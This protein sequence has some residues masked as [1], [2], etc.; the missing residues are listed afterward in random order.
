MTTLQSSGGPVSDFEV[1]MVDV[2]PPEQT[3]LGWLG[4]ARLG[5]AQTALGSIVVLTTSTI[6]RVM[7][8]ELS[9]PAMIPGALV[10]LHYAVQ[11]LRPRWG[12]GAD[13]GGRL[14]PWIIGGMAML[15]LGGIGAAVATVLMATSFWL[16]FLLSIVAFI[17]VGVGVGASGTSLLVLL[18][19]RVADARRPA[20]ATIVWIMMIVGF[21]ITAATAGHFL[22]PFS[23][24]RL[25]VV[26]TVVSCVAMVM[27]LLAV[28]GVEGK[29]VKGKSLSHQAPDQSF[30]AAMIEVWSEPQS[31]LF[32]IFIFISMVA[33]SAQD[34]ILEPFAGVVFAYTP[35]QSTKL[36]SVQH[37]GVLVGMILVAIGTSLKGGQLAGSSR[38]WTVGGCVASAVMLLLLASSAFIGPS[39][40]FRETVFMLG[41]ANGAFAISAIGAMMRLVS[42]G[43]KS[44]EGVRMGLWGAAQ[45]VAFGIGGFLGTAAVDFARVLTPS[46]VLAY[47]SVFAA[48]AVLFVVAAVL[49]ERVASQAHGALITT[50]SQSTRL[51]DNSFVL[52][53]KT[54]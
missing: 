9:L 30:R 36:A 10:A 32:A 43:H 6:N 37:G 34:L 47:A 46:P 40:P 52:G 49:A 50:V 39:F 22:D 23:M 45:G 2:G 48:E 21:I 18:S 5:L 1:S 26:T 53:A 35:G 33:Y 11:V 38:I 51:G 14:T 42:K 19:K 27:T 4:I 24:E 7:V 3:P 29:G 44:R 8:V 54:G 25:V 13:K 20:A 41:V 12:H 31:R 15:A 28:A 17:L 16:G